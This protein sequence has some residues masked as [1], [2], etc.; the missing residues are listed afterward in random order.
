MSSRSFRRRNNR[1]R[2]RPGGEGQPQNQ[3]AQQNG[4][5]GPQGRQP[6]GGPRLPQNQ[7]LRRG[8]PPREGRQRP[9]EPPRIPWPVLPAVLP[10]CPVCGKPVRDLASALTHRPDAQPAHFDCV[11]QEIRDANEIAPQEKICYLGG[12]TFGI[13]ELRPPGGPTRFVIRK[14]IQYE[15][16][17]KPQD[18]KKQL[19]VPC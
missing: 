14:R 8:G 2:H 16:K 1:R 4:N 19:Q 6:Q 3:N 13:I 15:E 11:M 7:Q 10:N 9:P 18:W 12:G 17:E 5:G